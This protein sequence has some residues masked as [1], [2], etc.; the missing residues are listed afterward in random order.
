M[1]NMK[2]YGQSMS[3][4]TDSIYLSGNEIRYI[5]PISRSSH[6]YQPAFQSQTQPVLYPTYPQQ[7]I[8][9]PHY[10]ETTSVIQQQPIQQPIVQN[11]ETHIYEQHPAQTIHQQ[12]HFAETTS[13]I[14]QQ[15]PI[16]QPIVQT[17]THTFEQKVHQVDNQMH[18]MSLNNNLSNEPIQ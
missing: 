3:R 9:Q 5:P 17:E 4:A 18:N 14:Q 8:Q 6:N 16:Q 15:H 1:I 12:P 11:T 7:P 13:V 10:V 2:N